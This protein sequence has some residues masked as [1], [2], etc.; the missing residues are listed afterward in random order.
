MKL[1]YGITNGTKFVSRDVKATGLNQFTVRSKHTQTPSFHLQLPSWNM[2][3]RELVNLDDENVFKQKFLDL[4]DKNLHNYV[5]V[6]YII[7]TSKKFPLN[8]NTSLNL[9]MKKEKAF[10]INNSK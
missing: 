3:P 1:L 9:K 2:L 6:Y 8:H 10:N 4:C 7:Y 5:Y